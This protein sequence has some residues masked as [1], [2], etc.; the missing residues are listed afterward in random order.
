MNTV[1]DSHSYLTYTDYSTYYPIDDPLPT[2]SGNLP[3]ATATTCQGNN[4]TLPTL[5]G[6]L[7]SCTARSILAHQDNHL[8]SHC[9]QSLEDLN[10]VLKNKQL[11]DIFSLHVNARSLTCNFDKI[12]SLFSKIDIYPDFLLI[13]E[14]RFRDDKVDWQSQLVSHS[15]YK[16]LYDNS[17]SFAGGVAIY[18]RSS[19]NFL[20][21]KEFRLDVPKCESIFLDIDL[22]HNAALG[23]NNTFLIGC[24]YRHPTHTAS[25]IDLFL[26]QLSEK[27]DSYNER[28]VPVLLMGDINI[29]ISNET[30]SSSLTSIAKYLDVL[31]SLG[32]SNLVNQHTRFDE[33]S[34][35]TLDHII[36]NYDEANIKYGILYYVITD[37]LPVYAIL[38]SKSPSSTSKDEV[39]P[40][41]MWQKIDDT[42]KDVFLSSLEKALN[43]IDLTKGVEENLSDLTKNTKYT[44]DECFP[45]KLLS[46]RAKK[47]AEQPWVDKDISN[48]ERQQTR[49]FRKF[50]SSKNPEDHKNYNAFR[51]KLDKTI[52]RRKKAYFRELIKE[53]N[54][55]K[56]FKKTWQAINKALKRGKKSLVRPTN[57]STGVKNEKTQCLK[58]IAN[59][60]NK[61]F[62]SIGPKL[63]SKL[64]ASATN[65][66]S[67]LGKKVEKSIF[68]SDIS[69]GEIL[70]VILSLSIKKGMG[71]DNIP[72][73]IIKW[74]AHLFAPILLVIFNKC[75]RLGYYPKGMKT[76]RVVPIHKEGDIN[77]V[78]NYRPISVL[79]QFNQI[80]E[81]ILSKRLMSFFEKHKVITSKQFGFLKKH[82]TEHAILD[83]KEYIMG[84]LDKCEITAVVF[85]DLQKA[86]DTV[87][88]EIL[89]QKL[90]HYGIRGL[91]YKLL[92]SYLS[93]RQQYTS[94][95][96]NK[97]DLEPITWGVPQGSVLGPLLFLLFIN[98]LPNSCN[99]NSWLFADDTSLGVSANSYE[100]LENRLNIE[101]NKVQ[102]WLFTNKLSV[103][104]GKKTQ[105]ILFIPQSRAKEKPES[106]TLKMA[107]NVIQQ[108]KIYK[109]LGILIDEHLNWKP[110]IDRLCSKLSSVCGILSKVR[111]YLDRNSLMMIYNSLVDS[112]LRYALLSWS[113]ASNDQL[114]RLIVLQNR[115]L[116]FIDFS[117]MQ[118]AMLPLYYHYKVL[119]L[120]QLI[121]LQ[122]STY[123]YSFHH[124]LLPY[125]FR[126]YCAVP[127]H[128]YETRYAENNFFL[129]HH[130]SKLSDLS[131]T[132]IGPQIW[133]KVPSHLKE[134]PFRKTFSKQL[135]DLYLSDLPKQRRTKIIHN[136][137]EL[138]QIFAE[139]DLDSTFLGFENNNFNGLQAI[140]EEDDGNV[141]FYGFENSISL[142]NIFDEDDEN[143]TFYGFENSTTLQNILDEDDTN[144]SFYG[145]N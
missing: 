32:L 12:M 8:K 111:H 65:P 11:G 44:I 50:I 84:C 3:S 133:A 142:Q 80:F 41:K 27:L 10:N 21:K 58:A 48:K 19:M 104:Y 73:K 26:K 33:K 25:A 36:T 86:F 89:L 97:S 43:Q 108:T 31:S 103:H 67:F 91:P 125:A 123:M 59:I 93:N 127:P 101:M 62:T 77:D 83:L 9:Y 141:T 7:S 122:Q 46:N 72:P 105:Y 140:F 95:E 94:V 23:G 113:T 38:K 124:N 57:V 13:T 55:K 138:R 47:K 81:R 145:F 117:P 107:N 64:P 54:T 29:D 136:I 30:R 116:R 22:S 66:A 139:D 143:F 144:F 20:V 90:S 35:S 119:P 109:Y 132:V 96:G 99:M 37:H 78:S 79:T 121:L 18:I 106:F 92:G 16:L 69:L 4:P 98:D 40:G 45:P 115:A 52:K 2:A 112:R 131:M 5:S 102:N 71:F 134:L 85:L 1:E 63:A 6:N 126:S 128:S 75:L 34:R 130:A 17:P 60:L 137:K 88:H 135:K 129:P 51:K 120:R 70:E 100:V 15:E 114:R 110:Q 53:A 42:K 76:A 68:L 82:S 61:H 28:N 74:A 87:S 14:T 39:S 118:T 49:L 24:I 56:D